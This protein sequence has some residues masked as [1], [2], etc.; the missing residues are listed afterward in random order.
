M[1][2]PDQRRIFISGGCDDVGRGVATRFLEEGAVVVLADL[3]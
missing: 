2:G 3:N 1:K